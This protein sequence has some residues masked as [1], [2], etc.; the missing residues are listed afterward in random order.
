MEERNR[1]HL[2]SVISESFLFTFASSR[3]LSDHSTFLPSASA[4]STLISPLFF[5]EG[6]WKPFSIK[7]GNTLFSP[8][9]SPSPVTHISSPGKKDPEH[10]ASSQGRVKAEEPSWKIYGQRQSSMWIQRDIRATYESCWTFLTLQWK[11][12]GE[13]LSGK[14]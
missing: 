12:S 9:T 4:C 8:T 14:S 2:N 13:S 10:F 11:K 3:L 1:R 7:K 6:D 5:R